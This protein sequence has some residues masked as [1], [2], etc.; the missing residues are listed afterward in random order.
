MFSPYQINAGTYPRDNINASATIAGSP[1]RN[2]SHSPLRSR[3][4]SRDVARKRFDI[5]CGDDEFKGHPSPARCRITRC[6]KLSLVAFGFYVISL[7]IQLG[8]V[9][10]Q[11]ANE[12]IEGADASLSASGRVVKDISSGRGSL[13]AG[14]GSH[15]LPDNILDYPSSLVRACPKSY[16]DAVDELHLEQCSYLSPERRDSLRVIMVWTTPPETFTARNQWT[17][18]S[19]LKNH[20]CA[21]VSVYS[22][23]LPL[24]GF[25]TFRD[26]GFDVTVKRYAFAEIVTE[27][28]PG[29]KWTAKMDQNRNSPHFHVH[30]SDMLRLLDRKSVV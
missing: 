1:N 16:S 13:R 9:P 25:K 10:P 15:L 29:H 30:T 4:N 17:V 2:T 12:I 19:L 23:T 28:E 24:Q 6:I 3:K 20:P 21:S 27:G 8:H 18:E 5:G 22:N 26:Y 7:W 11:T 14:G